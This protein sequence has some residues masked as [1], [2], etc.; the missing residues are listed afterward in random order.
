MPTIDPRVDG[1]IDN[2]AADFAKPV[3]RHLRKLVHE[4][5]PDVVET[6]KWSMPFFEYKGPLANMA[7]FKAHCA[8]GFWKQSLMESDAIPAEKTAM[9]A[10]GRITSVEDLPDDKTMIGLVKQA[11]KLNESGAKVERKA[12]TKDKTLVVPEVLTAALEQ[13]PQASEHF[14]AFP[15]SKKKDYIVWIN[16]AKSD[17]TRDKRLATAIEWLSEGKARHWKYE[18]C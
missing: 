4:A 10:F 7:S 11:V 2:K 15:Y 17:A 14:N 9:G 18:N 16:E 8:F 1:Y 13:N 5:C 6:M 3:L 12:P